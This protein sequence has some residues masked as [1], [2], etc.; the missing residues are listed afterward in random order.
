M[1][2]FKQKIQLNSSVYCEVADNQFLLYSFTH[3]TFAILDVEKSNF[4]HVHLTS[5][6][7][8]GLSENEVCEIA[9]SEP[10]THLFYLDKEDK[11]RSLP[12]KIR[13]NER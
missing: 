6:V 2:G 1:I 11:V 10:P 5:C 3:N 8:E 9:F 13:L 12:V 7:L 4:E